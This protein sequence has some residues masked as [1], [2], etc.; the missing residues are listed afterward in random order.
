MIFLDV[1]KLKTFND[2]Y[3]HAMGDMAIKGVAEAMNAILPQAPIKVRMGGDEFLAVGPYTDEAALLSL[4]ARMQ[5]WLAQ[6][7]EI[8]RMPFP[9]TASMSCCHIRDMAVERL[10]TNFLCLSYSKR[11]LS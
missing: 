5:L 3:G 6:Y 8:H 7:S 4:E 2:Q 1:D 10:S 9:L 11:F